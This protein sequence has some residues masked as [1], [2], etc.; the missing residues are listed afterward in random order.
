M[1]NGL[2]EQGY[3]ASMKGDR[4]ARRIDDV[5][6]RVAQRIER[7]F[8]KRQV[9]GSNP[10]SGELLHSIS[11][12]RITQTFKHL[13]NLDSGIWMGHLDRRIAVCS[14]QTCF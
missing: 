9:A 12:I 4:R 13:S 11:P 10:V 6:A 3:K 1:F 5:V 7:S 8:P 2:N 14:A